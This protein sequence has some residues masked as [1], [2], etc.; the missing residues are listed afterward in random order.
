ME[1]VWQFA[2]Q[3]LFAAVHEQ[4]PRPLFREQAPLHG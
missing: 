1:K 2:L 4:Q 3:F